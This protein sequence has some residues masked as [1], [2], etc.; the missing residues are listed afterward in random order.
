MWC[1]QEAFSESLV[2][3]VVGYGPFLAF[4]PSTGPNDKTQCCVV[5]KQLHL[6]F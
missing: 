4:Q 6:L 3:P 1:G 5:N 2:N